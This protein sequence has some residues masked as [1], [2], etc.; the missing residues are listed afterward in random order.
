MWY[1]S[2]LTAWFMFWGWIFEKFERWSGWQ[3]G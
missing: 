2:V 1:P 3:L